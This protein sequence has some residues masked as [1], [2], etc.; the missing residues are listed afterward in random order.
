MGFFFGKVLQA[1]LDSVA[2]GLIVT[3]VGGTTLASWM[4]TET[5]SRHP[6]IS[7]SDT[8]AGA[9]FK[10]WV[11][12]ALGAAMRGTIWLQGEQ[13]RKDSLY[14]YYEER[15]PMLITGWRKAWG[16]GDF[17]F[18]WV[19]LANFG[20][21]QASPSEA[22]SAAII[23]EAQRRALSLPNTAMAVAIDIGDSLHFSNKMEAA[24]RL[25]LIAL[26]HHY[27]DSSLVWSGPLFVEHAIDGSTV[28]CK[29]IHTGSGITTV[30][31]AALVGFSISGEEKHWVWA[32]TEI[33]GNIISVSS[34]NIERPVNVRYGYAGNP[35]GNLVNREGLPASPFTTEGIKPVQSTPVHLSRLQY[36]RPAFHPNARP[37]KRVT[38][39]GCAIAPDATVSYPLY[40]WY[41]DRNSKPVA[42]FIRI[43]GRAF[44]VQKE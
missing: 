23:R 31:D 7:R 2:V 9:M 17:P 34:P 6:E 8:T 5:L 29:F 15:F 21:R 4:D 27:G 40:R 37:Y 10:E 26:N 39:S 32:D 14:K 35:L 24:R 43:R 30:E 12:P 42:E 1:R 44:S 16:I 19:Q 25:S 3:A 28:N 41:P 20:T 13:D 11:T 22:G 36:Q 18:Y 38:P 33:K